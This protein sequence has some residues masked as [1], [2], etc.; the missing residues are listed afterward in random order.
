MILLVGFLF[1][2]S[3]APFHFWSPD[4]YDGVP[5]IV[6]TYIAI[7]PKVSVLVLFMDLFT[8]MISFTDS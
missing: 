6:T 5:T 3:A 1:K 8:H 4:V 2:I 7:I